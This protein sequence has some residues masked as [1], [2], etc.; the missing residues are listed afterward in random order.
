MFELNSRR[1]YLASQMI[2]ESTEIITGEMKA[3]K[4]E[5]LTTNS[6]PN[7]SF[8]KT[9]LSMTALPP[10]DNCHDSSEVIKAKLRIERPYNSL[11]VR[12]KSKEVK[13]FASAR[14]HLLLEL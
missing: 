8:I 7:C 10:N 3:P 9:S 11:K 12:E 14:V 5:H 6:N 4:E 1:V 13:I 2:S